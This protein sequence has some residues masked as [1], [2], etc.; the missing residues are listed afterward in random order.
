LSDRTLSPE[1]RS[2]VVAV[3]A[4]DPADVAAATRGAL[5]VARTIRQIVW[6][7]DGPP[8]TASKST[9]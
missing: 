1:E 9:S 6:V 5:A 7:D 3:V 2:G 8:I 4:A